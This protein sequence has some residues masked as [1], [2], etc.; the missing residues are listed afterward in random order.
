[1]YRHVKSALA[2]TIPDPLLTSLL[3]HHGELKTALVTHDWEKCL[4]RSG[5]FAET[6]MKVIHYLRTGNIVKSI[7]VQR[8]I[9][10]AERD[11]TASDEIRMTIPHHV[12]ALYDHRSNRGGTHSSFD[13]NEMDSRAAV[14]M[15]D[16]II[17]ELLRLYG[18]ASPA[19]ALA[20]VEALTRRRVPYVEEIDGELI[21]LKPD[22][23]VRQDI[24]LV[25][26]KRYP[27]RVTQADLRRWISSA[28]A[29]AIAVA[30]SRMKKAREVHVNGDGVVLTSR[31]LAAVE[32]EIGTDDAL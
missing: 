6:V 1:M 2:A 10:D 29:N 18:Q 8:E 19:E 11:T 17:A 16:W 22:A 7:S 27:S 25:L 21:P 30:V 13:P 23:T 5:K 4:V 20:V 28:K 14:S 26:Y 9:Q 15:A 24:G 3:D 12:R 32:V 31:G